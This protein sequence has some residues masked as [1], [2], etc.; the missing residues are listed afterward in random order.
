MDV[1][2]V[3]PVKNGGKHLEK[4]LCMLDQQQ[5]VYTYEIICVDSGSNDGS[6]DLIKKHRC[7][8]KQILPEEFGH[9]RTRNLGA[10]LGSGEFIC[11]LTQDA[12]PASNTWLQNMIDAMRKDERIAGGFGIHYTYPD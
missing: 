10:S 12:V 8:L 9:G 11:F 5:T 4:V 1:S 6:I 3:I 2:I 7:I